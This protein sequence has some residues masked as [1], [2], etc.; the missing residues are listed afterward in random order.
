M[1]WFSG[2][3]AEVNRDTWRRAAEGKGL[4]LD[5]RELARNYAAKTHGIISELTTTQMQEASKAREA[6]IAAAESRNRR[7]LEK[8]LAASS[9]PLVQAD[10][11]G[12]AGA[13]RSVTETIRA[14]GKIEQGVLAKETQEHIKVEDI[15]EAT[16]IA[17]NL[18]AA[19]VLGSV[20][21]AVDP[22]AG[23]DVLGL[24]GVVAGAGIKAGWFS[25]GSDAPWSKG[26]PEPDRDATEIVEPADPLMAPPKADPSP[27]GPAPQVGVESLFSGMGMESLSPP[28]KPWEKDLTPKL[29]LIEQMKA[30]RRA[31]MLRRLAPSNRNMSSRMQ[32][33]G[34][35]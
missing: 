7:A 11:A 26:T 4:M 35:F 12:A 27:S 29:S 17:S 22:G 13:D 10:V 21:E 32:P 34:G 16:K 5:I 30:K 3:V 20:E 8:G 25:G 15:A 1:G 24:L 33:L 6:S 23:A 9:D 14:R 19:G 18:G 28:L 2:N 31:E